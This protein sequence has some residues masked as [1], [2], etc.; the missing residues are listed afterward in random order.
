[1]DALFAKAAWLAK[2]E[3]Y[4]K[5]I[6]TLDT[7]IKRDPFYPGIWVLK[8]KIYGQLGNEKMARLC[9]ERGEEQSK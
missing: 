6:E 4:E 9:Q 7:I 3:D 2:T 1:M 5:C 8:A